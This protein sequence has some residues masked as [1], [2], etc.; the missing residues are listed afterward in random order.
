[1]RNRL[2]SA[3][4]TPKSFGRVIS[5]FTVPKTPPA[6]GSDFGLTETGNKSRYTASLFGF[7]A[8]PMQVS[9]L[10][11]FFVLMPAIAPAQ[12]TVPPDPAE[13]VRQFVERDRA[14]K[15]ALEN[16]G[17]QEHSVQQL[18]DKSGKDDGKPTSETWEVIAVEGRPYRR[19]TMRNE[20]PLPPRDREKEDERQAAA[21]SRRQGKSAQQGVRRE[22]AP[23]GFGF[24]V[25]LEAELLAQS[26]NFSVVGEAVVAGRRMKVW[27]DA[28]EFAIVRLEMSV[29]GE[30][31]RLKNGSTLTTVSVRGEDGVWL[32]SEVHLKF[33]LTFIKIDRVRG[34]VDVIYSNYSPLKPS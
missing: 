34:R 9:P 8:P 2:P 22:R 17:Y 4:V 28:T 10:V 26:H 24:E 25:Q 23:G 18:V 27:V 3:C 15:R 32:P 33:D 13:I 20:K 5:A 6:S 29:V 19:L 21:A 30:Q 14:N 16:Y 31:A 11:L 12:P 7:C 1:V